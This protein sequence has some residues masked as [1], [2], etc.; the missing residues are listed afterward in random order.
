MKKNDFLS[1]INN[2]IVSQNNKLK[3]TKDNIASTTA[4][5]EKLTQA[6]NEY[7]DYENPDKYEKLK[8]DRSRMCTKLEL[9]ERHFKEIKT[10]DKD[11]TITQLQGFNSEKNAIFKK[12]NDQIMVVVEQLKQIEADA[13][14]DINALSDLYKNWISAFNIDNQQVSQTF[15]SNFSDD[16]GILSATRQF[17]QMINRTMQLRKTLSK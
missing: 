16:A 6:I 11:N 13:T 2:E 5:I 4:E 15:I 12:Y 10:Q 7:S 14:K 17:M 1:M 3:E 9:L 8:S